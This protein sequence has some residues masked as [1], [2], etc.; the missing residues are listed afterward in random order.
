M[1]IQDKIIEK[2]LNAYNLGLTYLELEYND[3]ELKFRINKN[4]AR[5]SKNDYHEVHNLSLVN[6]RG[7]GVNEIDVFRVVEKGEITFIQKQVWGVMDAKDVEKEILIF[8][9]EIDYEN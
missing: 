5:K 2:V 6:V 7:N 3:M 9:E 4:H 8:L 1:T